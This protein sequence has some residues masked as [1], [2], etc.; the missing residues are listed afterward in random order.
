[1]YYDP[2]T[3]SQLSTLL[4]S[5]QKTVSLTL[6]QMDALRPAALAILEQVKQAT[7]AAGKAPP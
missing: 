5:G 6:E 1:M 7:H 2:P 3:L 4:M